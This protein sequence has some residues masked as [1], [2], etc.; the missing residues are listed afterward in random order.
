M[1]TV[2]VTNV[3]PF[4]NPLKKFGNK[5]NN[6]KK[7]KTG[8]WEKQASQDRTLPER[9]QLDILATRVFAIF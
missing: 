9:Q 5:P 4:K 8:T 1:H 6:V 7:C 2:K 3:H